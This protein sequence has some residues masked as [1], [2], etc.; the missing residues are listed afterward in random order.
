[1]HYLV[2]GYNFLFRLNADP[3]NLTERR[4]QLINDLGTKAQ[5]LNLQ[6]TLVFDSQYQQGEST[7][8]HYKE[9]EI[10]FTSYGETADDRI[11][12]EVQA[13]AKPKQIVV[14]TSDKKLAWFA[15]RCEAQTQ[16][17]EDFN[18]WL[19]KRY[20]NLYRGKKE[21]KEQ[22]PGTKLETD[23]DRWLR[24]FEERHKRL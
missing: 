1:M 16:S 23:I 8:S 10:L 5:L 22:S 2:D 18:T 21:K 19:E 11:I 12:E 4:Q 24:L 9:L 14:V 15:R 13:A 6:V 3:K 7:R 17:I 20:R